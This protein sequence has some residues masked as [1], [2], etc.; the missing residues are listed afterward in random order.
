M[1]GTL[2]G[3]SSRENGTEPISLSIRPNQKKCCK[4]TSSSDKPILMKIMLNNIHTRMET[5]EKSDTGKSD[6]D[7]KSKVPTSRVRKS[8]GREMW[9]IM[10]KEDESGA[11]GYMIITGK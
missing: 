4:L 6:K 5:Y 9:L 7:R 8:V 2:H 11:I 10:R 3:L 1:M